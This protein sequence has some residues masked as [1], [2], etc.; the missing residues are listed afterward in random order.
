MRKRKRRQR[1]DTTVWKSGS[2]GQG[3]VDMRRIVAV[4][5]QEAKT[6]ETGRVRYG[7]RMESGVFN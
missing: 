4:L 7:E 3:H 1:E 2:F 5:S 6:A